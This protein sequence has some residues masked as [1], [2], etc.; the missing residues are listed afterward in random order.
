MTLRSRIIQ[1]FSD[2]AQEINGLFLVGLLRNHHIIIHYYS[3]KMMKNLMKNKKWD[4]KKIKVEE[5]DNRLSWP[6]FHFKGFIRR[7]K[8]NHQIKSYR[9]IGYLAT[10]LCRLI[11]F[12][13]YKCAASMWISWT[14]FIS[15][16]KFINFLC[17]RQHKVFE[18]RGFREP[19][20]N[21]NGISSTSQYE[22]YFDLALN[23][24]KNN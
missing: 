23:F 3:L 22:K 4:R 15:I 1:T 21:L 12:V 10:L 8:I 11:N 5:G 14:P 19:L 7:G 18:W 16:K 9:E 2:K 6:I 24:Q 20:K 17:Q 13:V